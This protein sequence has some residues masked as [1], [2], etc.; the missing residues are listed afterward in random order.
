MN[1]FSKA[2]RLFN[3]DRKKGDV[4]KV[5][6]NQGTRR[7]ISLILLVQLVLLPSGHRPSASRCLFVVQ[8]SGAGRYRYFEKS[9]CFSFPPPGYISHVGSCLSSDFLS[10]FLPSSTQLI[11]PFEWNLKKL[12]LIIKTGIKE[13]KLFCRNWRRISSSRKWWNENFLPLGN[14]LEK[15]FFILV[16]NRIDII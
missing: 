11:Y 7:A 2:S 5:V 13:L 12:S 16:H 10:C 9:S 14:L 3:S 4:L 15:A 8:S 6:R 1:I